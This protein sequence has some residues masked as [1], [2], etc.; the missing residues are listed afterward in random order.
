MYMVNASSISNYFV[1]NKDICACS[2][3]QGMLGIDGAFTFDANENGKHYA[4]HAA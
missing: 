1:F 4:I 2:T 3:C